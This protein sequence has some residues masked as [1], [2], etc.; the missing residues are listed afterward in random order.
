MSLTSADAGDIG[1]RPGDGP[2][3]PAVQV[4]RWYGFAAMSREASPP[5]L[6]SNNWTRHRDLTQSEFRRDR[7]PLPL[8]TTGDDVDRSVHDAF[9]VMVRAGRRHS[10]RANAL[11][12]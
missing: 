4:D 10:S 1:Q 7:R 2:M 11:W 8:G 3:V 12:L 9:W 5:S 6:C